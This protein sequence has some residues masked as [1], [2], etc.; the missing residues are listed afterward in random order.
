MADENGHAAAT[1]QAAHAAPA[2]KKHESHHELGKLLGKYKFKDEESAELVSGV[3]EKT[4]Y[5]KPLRRYRIVVE[6]IHAYLEEA[7]YWTID[8]LEMSWS[9]NKF[10]K[11][12][13]IHAASEQSAFFGV[14]EQRLGMQ[15]D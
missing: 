14:S 7:Y 6:A 5:P 12:T 9:F 3:F 8:E 2:H 13:D 1:A 15:Q 4:G 11:I 10:E